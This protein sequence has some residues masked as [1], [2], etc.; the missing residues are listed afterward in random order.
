[1]GD[2]VRT[3]PEFA[4]ITANHSFDNPD[5]PIRLQGKTKSPVVIKDRVWIGM[6]VII[7]PGVTIGE[8]A[9]IGAGSIV[10]K[11]VKPY[12]IVAGNPARVIKNRKELNS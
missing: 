2:D 10:T 1:M 7:L 5:I 9:V 8:G 4:I 11:D 6:R 3:G 12:D